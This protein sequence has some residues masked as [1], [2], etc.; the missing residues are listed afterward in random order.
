MNI[1]LSISFNIALGLLE[2]FLLSICNMFLLRNKIFF[3]SA[4][5]SFFNIFYLLIPGFGPGK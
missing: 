3:N 1:F 5:F 2:M 4:W